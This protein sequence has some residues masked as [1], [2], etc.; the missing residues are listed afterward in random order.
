MPVE[1]KWNACFNLSLPTGINIVA[2]GLF[3]YGRYIQHLSN[4]GVPVNFYYSHRRNTNFHLFAGKSRNLW[5][6][7]YLTGAHLRVLSDRGLDFGLK[8]YHRVWK[9]QLARCFT[10]Q[11]INFFLLHGNCGP[12]IRRCREEGKLTIGEAVNMHP[13]TLVA[14]LE[15]EA[16]RLGL[17]QKKFVHN[18]DQIIAEASEMDLLL[19]PSQ[20]VAKSYQDNGFPAARTKV[21]P[22]G[23]G[24]PAN[25]LLATALPLA[26]E[27]SQAKRDGILVV[28]HVSLRKG[29]HLL[30]EAVR[31]LQGHSANRLKLRF[32][33]RVD[34]AYLDVLLKMGI[35]FEHETHVPHQQLVAE[36]AQAQMLVLPSLEDG[37]GMVVTEAML[38]GTPVIVSKYAGASELVREFGGGFVV[39]PYD[40]GAFAS[41]LDRVLGGD[42]ENVHASELPDWKDYAEKLINLSKEIQGLVAA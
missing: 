10:P 2:S 40:A 11:A 13:T 18:V 26:A 17:K 3:H 30:I 24:Q 1:Q 34:K 39:D 22:Y 7:E 42:V 41:V 14:C 15:H 25:R 21:I 9:T 38:A 12:A 4:F 36:M 6:K 35:N 8:V 33:G 23:V 28:A 20:A 5:L 27:D 37:F 16:R 19:A 31:K 32:V 29:H